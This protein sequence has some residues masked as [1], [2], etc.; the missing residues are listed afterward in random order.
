MSNE[1]PDWMLEEPEEAASD[2]LERVRELAQLLVK[3]EDDLKFQTDMLAHAKAAYNQTRLSDLPELLKE[4]GLPGLRLE[5]GTAIDLKQ[6][7]DASITKAKKPAALRWLEENGFGGLIKTK[8]MVEFAKDKREEAI[9]C[10]HKLAGEYD[11]VSL[12]DNVHPGTFKAFVK[13]QMEKGLVLPEEL[14]SVHPYDVATV[15]RAKK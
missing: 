8:V 1:A 4:V 7:I 6:N 3:Q 11:T 15:T 14:F 9:E 5:D 10:T 12:D 2:S 13:E